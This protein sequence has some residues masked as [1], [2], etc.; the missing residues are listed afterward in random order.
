MLTRR[1]RLVFMVARLA[2]IVA[3]MRIAFVLRVMPYSAVE[4]CH[5][6]LTQMMNAAPQQSMG[7]EDQADQKS[8]D[9]LHWR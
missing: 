1:R 2:V 3:A 7:R 9:V 4:D 8:R 5:A 6:M